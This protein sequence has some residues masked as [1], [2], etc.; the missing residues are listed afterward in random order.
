VAI[1]FKTVRR[2]NSALDAG[3]ADAARLVATAVEL[4]SV[5]GL[6]F[7]P[8]GSTDTRGDAEIDSLVEARTRARESGDFA[9]ADRIRAELTA[10]GVVVE[11]TPSGPVWRRS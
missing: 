1:V 7:D 3:D 4:A 5:L 2:A 9:V 6:S 11:D 8:G 10:L